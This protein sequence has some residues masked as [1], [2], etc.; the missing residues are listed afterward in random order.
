[1]LALMVAMAL[2]SSTD[3]DVVVTTTRTPG[4][5]LPVT[6]APLDVA[7]PSSTVSSAS[8]D[9]TTEQQISRWLDQRPADSEMPVWRDEQPRKMTGEVSLGIGTGDYS[10]VSGHVTMPL[11]ESGTLSLGFSQTKN[12]YWT[13][14]MGREGLFWSPHDEFLGPQWVTPSGRRFSPVDDGS[15]LSDQRRPQ[16]SATSDTPVN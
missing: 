15:L 14:P 11:G 8:Q 7:S 13:R 9:M 10:E 3:Q 2:V 16:R 5:G 12:G 6:A 4:S 1:M